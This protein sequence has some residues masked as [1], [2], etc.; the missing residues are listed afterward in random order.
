MITTFKPGD[1]V[2]AEFEG[3]ITLTEVD[4]WRCPSR[5]EIQVQ[6]GQKYYVEAEFLTKVQ[7]TPQPGDV[8]R[9]KDGKTTSVHNFVFELWCRDPL[10]SDGTSNSVRSTD[11]SGAELL[12]RLPEEEK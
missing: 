3:E 8:W 1:R 5:L 10:D 12:F 4:P 9:L 6:S 2:K 11:F 7:P